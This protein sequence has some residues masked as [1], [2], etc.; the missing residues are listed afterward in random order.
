[1]DSLTFARV[2]ASRNPQ[3][4]W[5]GWEKEYEPG[6][7]LP[8]PGTFTSAGS[9]SRGNSAVFILKDVGAVFGNYYNWHG[10]PV[11]FALVD[12]SEYPE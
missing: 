2:N 11:V 6:L 7:P 12:S 5:Y 10:A 1:M 3:I 4:T 9:I 8:G